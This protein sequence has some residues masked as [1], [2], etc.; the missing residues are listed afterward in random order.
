M[1]AAAGEQ[2]RA[3]VIITLL[4]ERGLE[5]KKGTVMNMVICILGADPG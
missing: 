3:I 2:G 4:D 5:K 1:R